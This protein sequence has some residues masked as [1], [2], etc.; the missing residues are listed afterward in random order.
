MKAY[1]VNAAV[2]YGVELTVKAKSKEEAK[3][4]AE[5]AIFDGD[6]EAIEILNWE[7]DDIQKVKLD[8]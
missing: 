2:T 5:D 7:I 3:M 8:S 6:G 4:V 1:R